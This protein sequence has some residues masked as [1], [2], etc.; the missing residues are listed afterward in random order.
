MVI[1]LPLGS[2]HNVLVYDMSSDYYLESEMNGRIQELAEQADAYADAMDIG[3]KNCI[4]L[5][6][7]YFAE[8]I[9]KECIEI[10]EDEDDGSIDTKPVR[11]AMHRIKKQFGIE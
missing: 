7:K 10:V 11:W 3:G 8:L 4:G 6:D 1:P 9:I 2:S 5:R